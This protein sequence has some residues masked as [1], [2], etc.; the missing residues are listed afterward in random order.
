MLVPIPDRRFCTITNETPPYGIT[1]SNNKGKFRQLTSDLLLWMQA[2]SD[3][4]ERVLVSVESVDKFDN[5]ALSVNSTPTNTA[6]TE[7]HSMITFHHANTRGSRAGR[8]R[9][10]HFCAPKQLSSACHA[11]FLDAPDTDHKHKLLTTSTSSLSPISST[12]PIFPTVSPT[13]TRSMAST[14]SSPAMFHG[15]AADERKSHLSQVMSTIRMR[16]RQH[17][18]AGA[19]GTTTQEEEGGPPLYFVSLPSRVLLPSPSFSWVVLLSP[20][21]SLVLLSSLFGGGSTFCAAKNTK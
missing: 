8:L 14:H 17:H 13:H 19:T 11:S 2:R 21:P 6:R 12:S 20:P 9:I 1:V 16:S 18:P 7:L 3:E 15:R 5:S 4:G 10:A